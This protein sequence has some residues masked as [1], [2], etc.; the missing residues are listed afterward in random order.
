MLCTVGKAN[1]SFEYSFS[2]WLKLAGFCDIHFRK[3]LLMA[4]ARLEEGAATLTWQ[5]C[6]EWCHSRT[7][8]YLNAGRM[9]KVM[10][11]APATGNE[12]LLP[13]CLHVGL[14]ISHS[15]P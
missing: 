3:Y 2:V 12:A 6:F 10:L 8:H 5:E 4:L 7:S 15:F 1:G 11:Q 14:G 13:C 9:P